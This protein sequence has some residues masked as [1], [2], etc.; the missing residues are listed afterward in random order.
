MM[1]E[2]MVDTVVARSTVETGTVVGKTAIGPVRVDNVVVK[3]LARAVVKAVARAVATIG[4]NTY[5][6]TIRTM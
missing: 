3:A 2:A 4:E 5:R 6:E 1:V